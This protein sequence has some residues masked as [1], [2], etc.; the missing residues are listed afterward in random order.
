LRKAFDVNSSKCKG[1]SSPER[2][3]THQAA[4]LGLSKKICIYQQHYQQ[5]QQF[6]LWSTVCWVL[7]V[8]GTKEPRTEACVVFQLW[9]SPF[10]FRFV[11][12]YLYTKLLT[13]IFFFFIM[14]FIY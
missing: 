4:K 2:N 11:C 14:N 1:S 5:R 7:K 3:T 13:S 10:T 8:D 9:R 6:F 12:A